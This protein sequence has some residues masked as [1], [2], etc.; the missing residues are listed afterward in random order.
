[1][2]IYLHFLSKKPH[3]RKKQTKFYVFDL[4]HGVLSPF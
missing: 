3:K 1:M 4:F 2:Q